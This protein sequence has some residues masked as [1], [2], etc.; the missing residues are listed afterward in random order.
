[1]TYLVTRALHTSSPSKSSFGYLIEAPEL[2][3]VSA[4]RPSTPKY[5][6]LAHLVPPQTPASSEKP[7]SIQLRAGI[8][9]LTLIS[10][11]HR[12][13]TASPLRLR[14]RFFLWC[15]PLLLF[16]LFPRSSARTAALCPSKPTA[17]KMTASA[18][19]VA[20][21]GEE[22]AAQ[23]L[24]QKHVEAPHHVTVEDV[25][26]EDAPS[27]AVGEASL[28]RAPVKAAVQQKEI[29]KSKAPLD[30]Q[31]HEVF[32]ELGASKGKNANVTPV[33]GAK[34]S[35]NGAPNAAASNGVSRSST[36]ASRA[37]TPS[38]T[39][40][41]AMFIPGRN[42]ESVTL[43]PQFVMPRG[44][45]KRPIQDILKDINRKSRANV[46]MA[47]ASNGRLRFDATGPQ[48]VAQQALKDLVQQIGTRTSVK[49]PVPHSARAHIIGKGGSTIRALQDKTGAKVQLPKAEESRALD[50]DDD[51]DA[52]ID[53]IVEGNALSA[54]SA[55]DE[56]LR[57]AG[58]RSA[59]MQ[60]KVRDIP[61]AFYPFIAG[62]G[63]SLVQTL[64]DGNDVQIRVPSYV[65]LACATPPVTPGPGQRPVFTP[66][67]VD[68]DHI[69]LAGD[70]AAVLRVRAEIERRAAELRELLEVEQ[71]SIQRGR[72]Q[73]IVGS[74]GVQPEDFFSETG[75][76]IML[77]SEE[78][79]D[80]VTVVG[81]ADRVPAA[82]DR[83]MDLAMGMQMSNMD[84]ARFHRNAPGGAAAHA[85]Y[86]TRYLRHRREID[87]IE[88]LYNTHIN[89]PFSPAGALPWELYSRE[90]K[91]AIRAQSEITGIINSH[92]P[93][94]MQAV[95]I[96]PFFHQHLRNDIM[97]RVKRDFGVQVVVPEASEPSAP[98]LLVF[99]GPDPADGPYQVPRSKPSDAEVRAFQQGL[100]DAQKHILDL[101]A[102]QEALSSASLDVPPKFHERLRRFIKKEQ[103]KRPA[104]QIPIRV[105]KVGTIVTLRGPQS[106]VES[107]ASKAEAFV[108]Q[109]KADE[110]ERGFTLTFD[111]P[112]K[113]ANHLIGKG[114]SNIRELRDRFDVEIQVQDGKVEL[115][116][117]RAKAEAARSHIQNLGRTLADETTHV[118]K[119]DPKYHREL[120]GSQGSQINRLQTRYKVLIFFPRSAKNVADDQSNADAASEAGKPRRQ[121]A[122]DEVVIRGPKKGADE[123]RDEIFSLH[124]YLEE[125]S[126][127]ATVAI[128]QKQVGSLIGQGGAALDELRQAT[129]ARIDVPA[130]RDAEI[131][132]ILI[133]GTASQ[134]AKARKVLEE[135]R[136]IFDDTI[137]ETIDVDKKF[138]KALIGPGG[139]NLRNIVVAAG[140]SDDRRSLAR[141]IQFP[142][143]DVDG[144]T[145]KVEGRTEVVHKIVEQIRSMVAEKESQ[146]T[147]L[148]E[149][150]IDH[151]RALIGRGGDIKR[152]METTFGVSIDVPRQGDGRTGVKVAGRPENVA[153]AKEHILGIVK[154]QQGETM[155]VPRS[156]HHAVS[157][158]GQIFRQ[159]R[160]NHRVTVD[161]G[162]QRVPAKADSSTRA[163]KGALPLITDDADSAAD[164]HSWKVVQ[165][166]S[167]EEGDI[168]WVLRGAPEDT[169][170][171]K[172]MI[173][174]ALEQAR[175][176]DWTGYLVLPDPKTYRHVIGPSGSKVSAIRQQ[177]GCRIQVPWDQAKDEAIEIVGSQSG[178]EKAKDLILAATEAE[179][180]ASS[181]APWESVAAHEQLF[182]LITGA[183]SGV[184]L[185]TAKRLT[186]EFLATRSH[187]AHLILLAT[188]RSPSKS[189]ATT[190][191]LRAYAAEKQAGARVHVVSLILDL[192]DLRGVRAFARDLVCG[193]RRLVGEG[194]GLGGGGVRVPRLDAVVFNAAYG[195]WV[196]C[197]FVMAAWSFLSRGL[198]Q[199]VTWPDFKKALPTVILNDRQEYGYPDKPL[200]GEIFTSC[201]FGHYMLGHQLIPLLSRP[202]SSSLAPGRIIWSSS[203]EA[204]SSVF[205]IDD[206]Q[207]LSHVAAYES[208]KRLTDLLAL[209]CS[210]PAARPYSSRWLSPP[211]WSEEKETAVVRPRVYLTHPG[212]VASTLFPLPWFLFWA[213]EFVLVLS[214]WL[215]SPWHTGDGRSGAKAAVWV[216]LQDQSAL[217]SQG[218]EYVKWG[219]SADREGRVDV[220]MTE[221]EGWGWQGRPED[222]AARA[223]DVACGVLHRSVG[224]KYGSVDATAEDIIRF[225]ELGAA[226]WREM[227]ELRSQWDDLLDREEAAGEGS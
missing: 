195:G 181:S 39:A 177:S 180:G 79:E 131:A 184:G 119:I 186:D 219:S 152:Q 23:K 218:A 40:A 156:L 15:P 175:K 205:S 149:V 196:G 210:L 31:S 163:D 151:H 77:P 104:D 11:E 174:K 94:R 65:A 19:D 122:P 215:G 158:N 21:G 200:L 121:Q 47:T 78:E 54:A 2:D 95:S 225:E 194:G 161:H 214:R 80:M 49:V 13:I 144:N 34:S 190:R 112:Q 221:V 146:V 153:K 183:N 20:N 50:E 223:A 33:W 88:Q 201:V 17:P 30:T 147:E 3:C 182:V 105:T 128:Q 176:N 129:G 136:A 64:E 53:V 85:G 52:T 222:E 173:Q 26:D 97:P 187:K 165:T 188:T 207:G 84:I 204:V 6:L 16:Q 7:P 63:N 191:T 199:S 72:H 192:C 116:G 170:K 22:S 28:P 125:H 155:Q 91:N 27:R 57:I 48:E 138:H 67:G 93:S 217:D 83:A 123:A 43:E 111:F 142:K 87:R 198:I 162:G 168:A 96:D 120:I 167:G 75:C 58:E 59:N 35:V 117:P 10:A 8:F 178:V 56:I 55:R 103:E 32:P 42:V 216:A 189:R 118:L 51:D 179:H 193:R 227:E 154:Q 202:A 114:G 98:V 211:P 148:V 197:D 106:A 133:K 25:P 82:L 115:K 45:L 99:E 92:P 172:E 134:V 132:E 157:N 12:F 73:F 4:N 166:A 220:K 110:K 24:L 126:V 62:P 90:G 70:R 140:G 185:G 124:K 224:R 89:T 209:T 5:Q 130:D 69:Q 76:A 208:A 164:A 141:A 102:K 160:N 212:I 101:I 137:V 109:E 108:E 127:T 81:P 18:I 159:L 66:A 145:I 44:Q 171:A 29:S 169:A 74:R 203:L 143:Q 9:H 14:R 1:M 37:A 135:K 41:P 61:V 38:N 107:L 71:L 113:Y 206:V 60:T 226:C 86:V 46:T 68:D 100:A 150:A 213:Y 139:S 36:P